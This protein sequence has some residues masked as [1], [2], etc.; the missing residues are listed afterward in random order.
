MILN[1]S[2]HMLNVMLNKK[3]ENANHW[4][5]QDYTEVL[6]SNQDTLRVNLIIFLNKIH[7]LNNGG[8]LQFNM[9]EEQEWK[10]PD[11]L[12]MDSLN[13]K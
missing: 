2:L 8:L 7:S 3:Q 5:Q 11:K 13:S 6:W 1:V 4:N 9:P 12:M 10:L